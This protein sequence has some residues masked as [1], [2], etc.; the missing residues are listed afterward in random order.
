MKK[1]SKTISMKYIILILFSLFT[2]VTSFA[3]APITGSL[4][5]CAGSAS[6]LSDATVGGIWSSS[7]TAVAVIGSAG[8]V[9][10]GMSAGTA[11]ITYNVSGIYSVATVTV[12]PTPSPIVGPSSVCLGQ[13]VTLTD[14]FSGGSWSVSGSAIMVIGSSSGFATAVAPGTAVVTYSLG[15]ACS[16][17][18]IITVDPLPNVYALT[19]AGGVT[20]YCAGSGGIDISL[21]GSEAGVYYQL[22]R[23]SMPVGSALA[24]TGTILNFGPQSVAATYSVTATATTGCN[25]AMSGAPAISISPLPNAYPITGGGSYCS[26]GAGSAIGLPF[27]DIGV[28]YM[29]Y[30]GSAAMSAPV[31]GTGSSISFGSYTTAGV[32]SVVATDNATTCT[33]MMTG[34]TSVSISALPAAYSVAGGGSY[35]TGGTGVTVVL[36]SS[37][38][39]VSYQLVNGTP[40]GT[41]IPG[42]GSSLAFTTV[43]GA[44]SYTIVGLNTT[45]GCSATMSG[46]ASVAVNPLPNPFIVTGGGSYCAGGT[47]LNVNLSNSN[48]GVNYDL[49]LG[50]SSTG[51]VLPGSTGSA[52][53][54]GLQ[55][56]GGTYTVIATDAGTMCTS[57]M[58]GAATVSVLPVASPSVTVVAS[59]GDTVCPG[60]MDTFSAAPVYGGSAPG[61]MWAV[62]AIPV[63]SGSTFSFIPANGDVVSVMMTTSYACASAPTA[64]HSIVMTV[65]YMPSITG[66]TAVCIGATS[67]LTNTTSGGT[68]GSSN[69]SVATIA[70]IGGSAGVTTGVSAGTSS[71]TYMMGTGCYAYTTLTVLPSP[72]VSASSSLGCGD[73]Y[74]LTA[75]GALSY[76]WAPSGGLSCST[77]NTTSV[78]PSATTV[79]TATGTDAL[80]CTN[81]GTVTVNGDRIFGHITFGGAKPDTLDMKVWLIQFNPADSSITSLDSVITCTVDSIGYYEFDAKPA[82]NYL[83]KAKLIHGSIPGASGYVPTYGYSSTNWYAASTVAHSGASDSLHINMAYGTVPSGPGFVGGYVYSGAGKGT[84]GETPVAGLLVYLQDITGRTLTYTYT[85][86]AGAYSFSNLAYNNY[87]VYPE[88]FDYNTTASDYIVI[89]AAHP[90]A[91]GVSFKEYTTSRVIRPYA[92]SAAVESVPDVSGVSLFPNPSSGVLNIQW[93]NLEKGNA[94]VVITDMVG[95]DAIKTIVEI[96]SKSGQTKIDLNNLNGGLYLITIKGEN[97]HYSGKLL[98]QK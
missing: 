71:I 33:N 54:F 27:S 87:V 40:V 15:S 39:G 1:G 90:A 10:T 43:T 28:S 9:C 19:T 88:E 82:G 61:Y 84:A 70:T 81:T 4:T 18:K 31:A 72:S 60:T 73:T 51:I 65:N 49:R 92:V 11:T 62:N 50:S 56:T 37:D 36:S 47:G 63:S 42:T 3:V 89:D 95:R 35:C 38:A 68:W 53:N 67:S 8:G 14:A 91:A 83:V 24:G 52:L 86:G 69:P 96:G 64:S 26:G 94:D 57:T 85:D 76:S 5:M 20:R 13:S 41:P 44:G 23:G 74:T 48:T 7:N 25:N 97:L 75:A 30:L 98:I 58:T 93:Q 59:P 34:T 32:Y 16:T 45:T 79:Y 17:S 77:C 46:S 29:L 21:S 66:S 78:S 12:M 2:S 80:G 6:T 22:Y 55:T